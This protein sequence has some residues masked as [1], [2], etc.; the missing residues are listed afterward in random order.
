VRSDLIPILSWAD[1]GY[2]DQVNGSE[3][4]PPGG[5]RAW[6]WPYVVLVAL[7]GVDRMI[8]LR[9][10]VPLWSIF[11]LVFLV[12][13]LVMQ[14]VSARSEGPPSQL[15]PLILSS[16]VLA[17]VVSVLVLL[18]DTPSDRWLLLAWLVPASTALA[19]KFWPH[20]PSAT[21]AVVLS[22]LVVLVILGQ[23]LFIWHA[24]TR[25]AR[26][27]SF[28][29]Q[30]AQICTNTVS[31]SGGQGQW[32]VANEWMIAQTKM[33]TPPDQRTRELTGYLINALRQSQASLRVNNLVKQ[34]QWQQL[35]R[36]IAGDL[37]IGP[38]CGVF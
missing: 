27:S 16:S 8:T 3:R 15:R 19:E 20:L 29:S 28:R 22:C 14:R 33:L 32:I 18:S 36:Q 23:L 4:F 35:A 30:L 7:L 31:R 26:A 34:G 21:L 24:H 12:I 13:A 10:N 17:V 38:S 25:R 11:A 9:W 5:G 37:D 2:V 1:T 6:G